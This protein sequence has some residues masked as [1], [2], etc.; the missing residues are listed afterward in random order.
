MGDFGINVGCAGRYFLAIA[1]GVGSSMVR[2]AMPSARL[3]AVYG[4]GS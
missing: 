3:I 2:S 4:G 1:G